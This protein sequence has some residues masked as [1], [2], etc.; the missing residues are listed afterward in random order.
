MCRVSAVTLK[1]SDKIMRS[2]LFWDVTQPRLVVSY[3]RFGTPNRSHI[4]GSNSP[5]GMD[6]ITVKGGLD[7]LSRNVGSYL[8]QGADLICTVAGA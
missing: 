1:V 5:R 4:L 6:Y 8:T 2:S 7:R 3:Q